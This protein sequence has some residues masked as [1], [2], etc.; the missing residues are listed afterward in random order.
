[1][2]N[3]TFGNDH[4]AY[5]ETIAGGAGAGP[6][7]HGQSAVHTHMTNTRIT[8]PE[9]LEQRYPVLLREFSIRKGSGGEGKFK[10]G[11]GVIREIEFLAPLKV[12]ILSER[13]V[14]APYGM[15]GGGPGEKGKNLL[16][17]KDGSITDVGGKCQLEVEPGERIRICTPGGGSWGKLTSS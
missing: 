8:D 4:F 7:W 6:D 13:R 1:M 15:Q 9:V 10:G 5:Y 3:L 16:I 12:A 2:N 14:Y 11:D 17:K